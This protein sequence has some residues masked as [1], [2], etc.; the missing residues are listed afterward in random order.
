[1]DLIRNDIVN[2]VGEYAGMDKNDICPECNHSFKYFNGRMCIYKDFEDIYPC[3]CRHG[4]DYIYQVIV[5]CDR[6]KNKIK[7]IESIDCTGGFYKASKYWSKFMNDGENILCD[8]C[9]F[10]DERYIKIY[11][12]HYAK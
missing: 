12:R 8:N 11:G 7:G 9:M 3:G 5:T 10:Q 6:C 1:M 2:I 4:P